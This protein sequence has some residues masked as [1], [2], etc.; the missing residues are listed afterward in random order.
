MGEDDGS[1]GPL[2]HGVVLLPQPLLIPGADPQ[3][4]VNG[5][6]CCL[7]LSCILHTPVLTYILSFPSQETPD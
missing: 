5:D 4:Q 3:V 6:D 7:H 2:T 1:P